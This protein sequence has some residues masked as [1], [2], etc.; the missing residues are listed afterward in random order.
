M[1]GSE[2]LSEADTA[3]EDVDPNRFSH[4][5]FVCGPLAGEPIVAMHARFAHCVRIAVGVSIVDRKGP[6]ANGFHAVAP[7]DGGEGAPTRD[8]SSVAPSSSLSVVGVLLT[9]GQR[10]YGNKRQHPKVRRTILDCLDGDGSGFGRRVAVLPLDTRLDPYDWKSST[11]SEQF[12]AILR[13]TDAV[14]TMRLHGMVL[15]LRN[16]VPAVAVD[17]IAGGAKVSAQAAAWNWPGVLSPESLSAGAIAEMVQWA[18]SKEARECAA[19]AAVAAG[20]EQ[21]LDS[22]AR[23]LREGIEEVG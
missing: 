8:L 4:L 10:E 23:M 17:P 21:H 7:R 6:A 1:I 5:V 2:T 12:E 20:N 19:A 11:S 9:D 3:Y 16:G 22:L 13:R 18:L 14:L 15:A